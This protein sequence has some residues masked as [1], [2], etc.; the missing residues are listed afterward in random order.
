MLF[1]REMN[2]Q[3]FVYVWANYNAV[4]QPYANWF[5]E[6]KGFCMNGIRSELNYL[7]SKKIIYVLG[8][9]FDNTKNSRIDKR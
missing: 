8:I 3:H 7:T 2:G 1:R 4:A 5:F 6:Y 9:P